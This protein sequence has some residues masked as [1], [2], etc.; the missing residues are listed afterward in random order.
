MLTRSSK[1]SSEGALVAA[2]FVVPAALA[3]TYWLAT[4][5]P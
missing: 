4:F 3:L 5:G 2:F 1:Q